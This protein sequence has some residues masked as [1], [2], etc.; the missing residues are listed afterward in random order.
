[1]HA[2]LSLHHNTNTVLMDCIGC[3]PYCVA[4]MLLIAGIDGTPHG[5]GNDG[6]DLYCTSTYT[7]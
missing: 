6:I 3:M 5:H 7:T 1:M 4:I 2:C